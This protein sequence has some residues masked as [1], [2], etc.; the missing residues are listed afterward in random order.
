LILVGFDK[1]GVSEGCGV[2]NDGETTMVG[3]DSFFRLDSRGNLLVWGIYETRGG[4]RCAKPYLN[5]WLFSRGERAAGVSL[6]P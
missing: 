6:S 4:T 3:N 2:E 5:S 1:E